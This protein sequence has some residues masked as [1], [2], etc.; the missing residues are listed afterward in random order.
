MPYLRIRFSIVTHICTLSALFYYVANSQELPLTHFST[1]NEINPLPGTAATAIFQD[2]QGYIWMAIYGSGLV[3]YDGSKMELF[4]FDQGITTYLFSICQDNKDRLWLGDAHQGI[5]AS[6]RSLTDYAPGEQITFGQEIDGINFPTTRIIG[7]NNLFADSYGN[8]W[9]G[10]DDLILRY[11]YDDQDSLRTD[12][13]VTQDLPENK[14]INFSFLQHSDGKIYA[15]AQSEYLLS[16]D[17]VNYEINVAELDFGSAMNPSHALTTDISYTSDGTIW[18]HCLDGFTWSIHPH[19]DLAV[20][21]YSEVNHLSIRA[22]CEIKPGHVLGSSLTSGLIDWQIGTDVVRNHSVRNG[23]LANAVWDLLQDRE[24]N[25]WVASN[26]GVSRMPGDYQAFGHYTSSSRGGAPAVL[27]DGGVIAVLPNYVIGP[28]ASGSAR[29]EMIAVGTAGGIAFIRSDGSHESMTTNEGLISNVILGL[30]QDGRGRLW[31][32]GRQGLTCIHQEKDDPAIQFFDGPIP[33][34]LW[35]KTVYVRKWQIDHLNKVKRIML[36]RSQAG[37]LVETTWFVGANS[38]LML[39]EETWFYF[40]KEAGIQS[41]GLRDLAQDDANVI[42]LADSGYGVLRSRFPVT[43]EGLLRLKN[44]K[45]TQPEQRSSF[46]IRDTVFEPIHVHIDADTIRE[47]TG[48]EYV[49]NMLWI[50]SNFGV[51]AMD[52]GTDTTTYVFNKDNGLEPNAAQGLLADRNGRILWAPTIQGLYAID[53]GEK[54]II[55]NIRQSDGLI[56]D[57]AWGHPSLSQN[58]EGK[59]FFATAKGLSLYDPDLDDQDTLA[60]I[61]VLRDF[62][63]NRDGKSNNELIIEYA[64]L[65]YTYEKGLRYQTK[66]SGYDEDWSEEKM[67]NSIRYTNLP[68]FLFPREYTFAVRAGDEKGNWKET[69]LTYSFKV[70]PPWYLHWVPVLMYL[71]LL[72]AGIIGYINWRTKALKARQRKLEKTVA[73]RTAEI[74]AQKDIIQAEKEKS[75]ELLLNILPHETAEELKKNGIAKAKNYDTVTVLFTDFKNFTQKAEHLSPELLVA[76]I[77][78][79]FKAFDQVMEQF[80]VEKIKTVG[81]S[82]MA[83]AGLPTPTSTNPRDAVLAAL[84]IRD[85]MIDQRELR[86]DD[87]F[88]IR[89]G[90]HTGPVVAGIVGI[91]KFA[92][93]IWGDTVNTASRMESAG[94]AGKV[95]ISHHTYQYLKDDMAFSFEYRGKIETKHKGALEMYFVE[96]GEADRR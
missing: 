18:G 73:E 82:Y 10:L 39:F 67:D 78:H 38:L 4:S 93:D 49:N 76:E 8:V 40:G 24:G 9:T 95:N 7:R 36:P 42:Y 52:T 32:A 61:V 1:E 16:I 94:L 90:V 15:V 55:R 21:T 85:Y 45:S 13:I 77:D 56:D 43:I 91:K 17:P 48:L 51:L 41:I 65:S 14:R 25:I 33:H 12:S 3:R 27:P 92:Y 69:A 28:A 66:L 89:I 96:R 29:D 2:G 80:Q 87:T 79:C 70:R 53:L 30:H 59:L 75:D 68:A 50:S 74:R 58:E 5:F 23:L 64:G 44:E 47:T 72:I 86:G 54:R 60:P 26:A 37:E 22:F 88:E 83:A 62:Q 71:V 31:V 63:L 81:D 84:A 34:K 19:Q 11:Y 20:K 46:T 57:V 6:T 35:N